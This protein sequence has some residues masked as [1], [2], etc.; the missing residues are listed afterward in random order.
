MRN[1]VALG[2]LI[3]ILAAGGIAAGNTVGNGINSPAPAVPANCQ[4]YAGN[5]MMGGHGMMGGGGMMGPGGIVVT[6]DPA[7]QAHMQEMYAYCQQGG[8]TW[9]QMQAH[10]QG[11]KGG[12][13]GGNTTPPPAGTTVVEM[14]GSQFQTVPLRVKVGQ[15]VKWVNKDPY[16]HTVTSDGVGGPLNS[17]L[18]AAGGSWSYAFTQAGT[19]AYHCTPHSYQDGSG[20]YWGMVGSVIVG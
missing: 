10:C 5:G 18:I 2:I 9:Q 11:M 3:A 17:P 13:P 6:N 4:D 8:F 1:V 12:N 7:T 15:T 16:A 19:Y 14:Q 20:T